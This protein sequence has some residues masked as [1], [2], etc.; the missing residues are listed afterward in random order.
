MSAQRICS[1]DEVSVKSARRVEIDGIPVAVVKDSSGELHAV[2][3]TCSH[4]EI[5]LS[6]GDVEETRIK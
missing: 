4:A 3:D 6:E 1:A 5:S 2:G